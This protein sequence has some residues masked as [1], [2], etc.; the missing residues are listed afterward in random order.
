MSSFPRLRP[1]SLLLA[2]PYL[3]APTGVRHLGEGPE[4]AVMH[5]FSVPCHMEKTDPET[6]YPILSDGQKE[7]CTECS[8]GRVR[9][10][11]LN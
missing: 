11:G 2:L 4:E 5:V 10:E 7:P 3:R 1:L 9:T 6:D 8:E